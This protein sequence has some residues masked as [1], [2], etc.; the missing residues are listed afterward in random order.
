MLSQKIGRKFGFKDNPFDARALS[1]HVDNVLPIS[2][3]FV[4]RD[5]SSPESR[6]ITNILSLSGGG[7]F[8]IEGEV[9]VGKTTFLNYHRYLWEH[10]SED[11]LFTPLEEISVEIQW[12]VKEFLLNLLGVLMEKLIFLLG[13]KRCAKNTL[14][15]QIFFLTRVYE[16]K[17]KNFQGSLSLGFIGGSIHSQ[18]VVTVPE[19]PEA[20]LLQYFKQLVREIKALGYVGIFLH[21]D[22]FE[23]LVGESPQNTQLFFHRIRD[24][25]QTPDVYYAFVGYPGFYME[26]IHP[27]ERVSSIF[28]LLPI[29]LPP[30]SEKEV[31]EAIEK[32]YS[33]LSEG[34]FTPPVERDFIG[35][36]YQLYQGKFRSI[37]DSLSTLIISFPHP[38]PRTLS[39][40]EARELL[41]QELRRRVSS[42][43]TEREMTVLL[44][45]A[46]EEEAIGAKIAKKVNMQP[47]NVS[48]T[49]KVLEK[50]KLIYPSRRKGNRIYYRINDQLKIVHSTPHSLLSSPLTLLQHKFLR[51]LQEKKE[52]TFKEFTQYG[53]V[54]VH[55]ARKEIKELLEKD[56]IRKHGKTKGSFY[57]L[58]VEFHL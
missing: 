29:L 58:N 50:N 22:N 23:P 26:V 32:R 9:G 53:K 17:R 57:T 13:E 4:G 37:L 1:L 38:S 52:V 15:R 39:S 24:V 20:Q 5:L 10:E 43:L 18:D 19:V 41:S 31:L 45:V 7:R 2:Q 27:I 36:L 54:S 51:L 47:Q 48:R 46:S 3:A 25:L 12:G 35:E 40:Q 8:V 56:I 16:G 42:L 49:F 14:F 44:A 6:T 11:P 55:Q 34:E 30:L 21:L 33:L 28:Y